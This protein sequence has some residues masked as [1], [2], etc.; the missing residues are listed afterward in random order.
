MTDNQQWQAPGG[1]PAAPPPPSGATA[2]A[3]Y[4][5]PPPGWTPPPK[6]GIIPLR[7]LT[8]GAILG[9]SFQ[10]LRRNPLPTLGP[11]L[12]VSLVVAAIQAAGSAGL[13]TNIA[14]QSSS[15]AYVDSSEAFSRVF[16]AFGGYLLSVLATVLLSLVA[17][18]IVQ[19]MVTL[20]V[21]SGAVGERLRF[22]A[23]WRRMQGRRG[24]VVGWAFLLAGVA[25]LV[26]VVVVGLL[27]LLGVAG[28]QAGAIAAVL[29]G[30][31]VALGLVVVFSWLTT[32]LAFVP[33]AIVLE[34]RSIRNSVARSWSLTRGFFWR[35]FGI[36]LLVTVMIGVAAAIV[37]TPVQLIFSLATTLGSPNGSPDPSSMVGTLVVGTIV[38]QAVSA[39]IGSI[40]LVITTATT[41]LLYIDVRMRSEGLDL[42]LARYVEL[43]AAARAAA[44]DPYGAR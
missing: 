19:A 43:P 42:D 41:A 23:L 31:L 12:V 28:G 3:G 4:G 18:S 13:L 33:A 34:R 40:G 22:G 20:S 35:T 11:A 24:A 2:P 27:V 37:T 10:A 17:T 44:P 15:N 5:P 21:A 9:G 38:T 6:P 1:M 39:V 29:L 14:T 7:P 25:L 30:V 32:K 16:G 36:R 8:L 26:V